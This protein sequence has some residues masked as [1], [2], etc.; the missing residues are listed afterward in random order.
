MDEARLRA[1]K[2]A[3]TALAPRLGEWRRHLHAHPELSYEEVET[4]SYVSEVLRGEGLSADPI[5]GTGVTTLVGPAGDRCVGLRA[6]LDALPIQEVAGRAYG[7]TRAGVMHACGHDVHTACAIGA[8]VLLA[9]LGDALPLPV[10]VLFQPGEERLPGGATLVIGEGGLRDP[11]VVAIAALHVAPDLSVG[12]VGTRPG[13]YMAS[14]DEVYLRLSGDGG[15]GALPHKTVD[16]VAAGAQV[17]TA[18]QQVVSRKAPAHVPSVLSFGHIASVGGATNVLPAQLEIAG[19]F[20]TYDEDWRGEARAWIE[21][22]ARATAGGVGAG[23]EV[24]IR[25]GYPA[26]VNDVACTEAVTAGLRAALGEDAVRAL[27][28]R[29][30]AEDFAWYL[31]EVPGTFFRLGVANVARGITAGVHTPAFDVDEDCLAV[32]AL[33]L[34]TAAIALGERYVSHR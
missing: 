28:L 1:L 30:T 15:H 12:T 4:Q 13:A 8:A 16:L 32:G 29:P 14:S 21:R 6:D 19:T 33:A 27:G 7:S 18:L 9:D 11:E 3:A 10:K 25:V 17:I 34:A 2:T 5:A 31:R 23:I 22:I 24:D 26:L 20:R